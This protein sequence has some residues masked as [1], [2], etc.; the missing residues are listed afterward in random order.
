MVTPSYSSS[1]LGHL[2]YII[3]ASIQV[4]LGAQ[5]VWIHALVEDV[6]CSKEAGGHLSYSNIVGA[7]L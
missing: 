7:I 3:Y 2:H 4:C 6:T 1:Y 5:G